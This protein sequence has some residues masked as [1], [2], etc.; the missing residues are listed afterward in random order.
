MLR[1]FISNR[2]HTATV[3]RGPGFFL[4]RRAHG[5]TAGGNSD[6]LRTFGAI[7]KAAVGRAHGSWMSRACFLKNVLYT[8]ADLSSP[9][10]SIGP[11]R[12]WRFMRIEQVQR[13]LSILLCQILL[14]VC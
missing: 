5:E 8:R 14:T 7:A 3:T 12:C 2:I 10:F 11:G 13:L 6:Q 1:S 4:G 9:L